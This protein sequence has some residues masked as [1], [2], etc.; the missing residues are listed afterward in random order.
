MEALRRQNDELRALGAAARAEI[1]DEAVLAEAVRAALT[2]IRGALKGLPDRWIDQ[3]TPD[4]TTLSGIRTALCELE[5]AA[6]ADTADAGRSAALYAFLRD[7]I[8]R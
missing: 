3:P 7:T 4:S 8:A 6:D 2:Q 1:A 5:G